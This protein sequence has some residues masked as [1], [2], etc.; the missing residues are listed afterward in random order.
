M[1]RRW[2]RYVCRRHNFILW[3]AAILVSAYDNNLNSHICWGLSLKY[4]FFFCLCCHQGHISFNKRILFLYKYLVAN[5]AEILFKPLEPDLFPNLLHWSATP[6]SCRPSNYCISSP[7]PP[8]IFMEYNP[9]PLYLSHS[10]PPPHLQFRIPSMLNL[11]H[12]QTF[13][14][15]PPVASG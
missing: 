6:F 11:S 9:P 2:R 13:L 12:W 5:P 15:W 10:Q 8:A 4:C 1:T 3:N 14:V 7:T